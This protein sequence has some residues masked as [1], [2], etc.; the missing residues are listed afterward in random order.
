MAQ[1]KRPEKLHPKRGPRLYEARP[2]AR[3]KVRGSHGEGGS[4]DGPYP[5][6]PHVW[7]IQ[8][9]QSGLPSRFRKRPA[10]TEA[11]AH[12]TEDASAILRQKATGLAGARPM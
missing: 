11:P 9:R 1:K 10:D 2:D 12:G 7:K 5:D 3:A 4:H 8:W 6:E